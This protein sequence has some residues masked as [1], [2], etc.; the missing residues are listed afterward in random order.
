M[1]QMH[2]S[3]FKLQAAETYTEY[4]HAKV[5]SDWVPLSKTTIFYCISVKAF[6]NFALFACVVLEEGKK[7]R[8]QGSRHQQRCRFDGW[9]RQEITR[10]NAPLKGS[11]SPQACTLQTEQWEGDVGPHRHPILM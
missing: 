8:L 2:I 7:R 3:T 6:L 1:E 4:K 9:W 10:F 5:F 11:N